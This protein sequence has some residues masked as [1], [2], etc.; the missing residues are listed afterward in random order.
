MKMTHWV[1]L[2][3]TVMWLL[4]AESDRQSGVIN[5]RATIRL[6]TSNL[7]IRSS[8]NIHTMLSATVSS[9]LPVVEA[10]GIFISI[11]ATYGILLALYRLYL[12]P[13]A[14]Y[15]GPELAAATR[16]YEFYFDVIERGR[17]AW[18]IKCMHEVYGPVVR[19]TPDE[20]HVSEPGAEG[21]KKYLVNFSKG[22]RICLGK[23]LARVEIVYTLALLVRRWTG[24]EGLG[25]R[26]YETGRKDADV[27]RD[28]FNP[29]SD[30]GS[31]G[32]RVA[33]K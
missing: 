6:S 18:E 25:M 22:T 8:Y 31:K 3:S 26:L 23:D 2:D 24:D 9:Q 29:Y 19:V 33:F 27:G 7:T 28:L 30:F 32:V 20:L 17:F 15:P 1:W 4:I 21:L 16:W 13:L 11:Y 10:I 14:R 5:G 12:H